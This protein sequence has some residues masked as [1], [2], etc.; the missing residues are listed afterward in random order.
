[1]TTR[2]QFFKQSALVSL[3]PL[4]PVF[5][6]RSLAAADARPDERTLV[7]IQLDGGNDGLNTVIPYADELYARARRELR[8]N[9]QEILKLDDSVG[10]HPQ[11]KPMASLFEEGRLTIVQGVGYPNP[12]RSHFESM[13]IWH[14]AR[15]AA[16]QHDGVGWL[17]R[18]ADLMRRPAGSNADSV[19]V[20]PEAVPVAIRARRANALSLESEN[21]LKLSADVAAN[22]GGGSATA[23]DLSAFVQRTVDQSYDA[24]RRFAESGAGQAGGGEGYPQSKL[25][26]KLRMVSKLMK[27]GGATRI[28]YVSQTGYDTHA[29]QLYP[30]GQLLREF[31]TA[32]K[33][34]LDELRAAK[35]EERV[36]VMAFS[37]FGRRVEEN[38]S[39]GTDHGVAGPVFLAGSGL[40]KR[41]VGAHPS[42]A[43]LD[44]GDLK[45]AVDFRQVYATLLER[46]LSVDADAILGESFARLDCVRSA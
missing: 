2:R 32:L 44:A 6:S 38:A 8:I 34:F 10:L 7:V 23:G 46:W 27:L 40:Q 35:V 25:G 24:A 41:L 20:G 9:P 18:A 29:A 19:Y 39:A 22:R 15:L 42:L 37:E 16:D 14:H 5:L 21:D 43:D 36:V 30:H 33:A 1:M 17:G 13:A 4:V 11:M 3:S 45:T 31:S 28:Y 12:N 26:Q